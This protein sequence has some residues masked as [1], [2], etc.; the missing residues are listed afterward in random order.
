MK[1]KWSVPMCILSVL[2]LLFSGCVSS[3]QGGARVSEEAEM[4]QSIEEELAALGYE[5]PVEDFSDI[6]AAG[7]KVFPNAVGFGIYTRAGRG[8]KIIRVTTLESDGPGSLRAALEAEGPRIVVFEVGGV[9]DFEMTTIE[10]TSPFLTVAGQT[11]PSPGIT[12]I[13]G[14][15]V[16]KTH[17]VLIQHIRVRPGDGADLSFRGWEVDGISTYG[18]DAYNVVIDHCSVSWAT[19]EGISVSGPRLPRPRA[20]SHF[21]TVSNCIIAENLN[22]ATHSKGA[23]S[24]GALIHD[25]VQ[26]VAYIGNLFAHNVDRNPYAKA[27]TLSV[28]ANNLIYNPGT[29][30]I[31]VGYVPS[32][33]TGTGVNPLP[34]RM[35]AVGNVLIHGENT[36]PHLA[37]IGTEGL[38][39]MEDNLAFKKDGSP[40][41]LSM[42]KVTLLHHKP[43]WPEGFI[44]VPAEELEEHI[45]ANVGARPADRDSVDERI[46]RDLVERKGRIIDSQEE[47]G[48]YPAYEPVYRP[49]EIPDDVEAWLNELAAEVEGRASR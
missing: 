39:F 41:R 34:A 36:L 45:V 42:G 18:E 31:R 16:V 6:P 14:G 7:E 46:I 12:I 44:P 5:Y 33:W 48:G 29:N 3:P 24:K 4:P 32:E 47:V 35:T 10:I 1:K 9:I 43:L 15:L 25:N 19:D 37:L 30:A 17:D 23:H 11:A 28:V 13:R 22:N 21:V 27:F 49:L 8:G 26:Y 20:T 38:V 40:A 2:M